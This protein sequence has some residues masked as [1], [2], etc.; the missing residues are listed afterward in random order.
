MYL[1]NYADSS[2]YLSGPFLKFHLCILVVNENKISLVYVVS[3]IYKQ[4]SD[5][6]ELF[7]LLI[8][9]CSLQL[10]ITNGSD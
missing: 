9:Y 8:E 1:P 2:L 10:K 6:E 4:S 5:S 7:T 3:N